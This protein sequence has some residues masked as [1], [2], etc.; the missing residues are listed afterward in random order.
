MTARGEDRPVDLPPNKKTITRAH[1]VT[2]G[3]P[4]LYRGV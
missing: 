4:V 2:P 1:P 3:G